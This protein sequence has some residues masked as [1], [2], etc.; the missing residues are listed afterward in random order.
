MQQV[1]GE[2]ESAETGSLGT[3]DGATPGLALAGDHARVVLTRQLLVHA[4]EEANLA[5]A[6]TDITSGNILIR[7]D[8]VTQLKHESLAETHDL[9]IALANGVKVTTTL[10]ASHG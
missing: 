4:V 2:V 5:A 8:A 1:L 7:T 6:H 3:Q 9:G 10:G